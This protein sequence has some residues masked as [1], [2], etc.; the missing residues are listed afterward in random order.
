MKVFVGDVASLDHQAEFI[1][2]VSPVAWETLLAHVV[3]RQT[4]NL[5]FGDLQRTLVVKVLVVA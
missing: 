4:A 3:G 5:G 1:P 2:L